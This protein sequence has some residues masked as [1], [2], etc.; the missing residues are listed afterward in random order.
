MDLM[1]GRA[2]VESEGYARESD[3][4][5]YRAQGSMLDRLD[6]AALEELGMRGVPPQRK[7][8]PPTVMEKILGMFS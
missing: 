8:V 6:Q 3:K 1:Q 7:Q 4:D 2:G 5:K